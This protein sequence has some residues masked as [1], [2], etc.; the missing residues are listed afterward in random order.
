MDNLRIAQ[1]LAIVSRMLTAF[2]DNWSKGYDI[3]TKAAFALDWGIGEVVRAGAFLAKNSGDPQVK[4][5]EKPIL[6]SED[7]ETVQSGTIDDRVARQTL[8]KAKRYGV[9]G[10]LGAIA[11]VMEDANAHRGAGLAYDLT[12][13]LTEK[14]ASRKAATSLFDLIRPRSKVTIVNRFGQE[15]TGRAVMCGPHGW[16][17]NMGGRH[18][19]P[20]IADEENTVAVGSKRVARYMTSAQDWP[21]AVLQFNEKFVK[22]RVTFGPDNQGRRLHIEPYGNNVQRA[23]DKV[24]KLLKM[25]DVPHENIEVIT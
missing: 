5:L 7:R 18:G 1:E 25:M 10:I 15:H 24:F 21:Y 9:M 13:K 2:D 20:G 4:A 22:F 14:V 11:G 19:T 16:V 23:V 6:R 12:K 3:G 17:L 8:Q